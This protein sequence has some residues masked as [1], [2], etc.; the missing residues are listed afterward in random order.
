[1]WRRFLSSQPSFEVLRDE[2]IVI[3]V[4]IA[5]IDAVNLFHLPRGM[6]LMRVQAP[7]SGHQSLTAQHFMHSGDASREIILRVEER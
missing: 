7:S 3:E 1:M 4:R 6:L 2:I 5:F